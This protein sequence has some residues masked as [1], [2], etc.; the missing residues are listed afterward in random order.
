MCIKNIQLKF[1]FAHN[2]KPFK[3]L[4]V[5]VNADNTLTNIAYS[6]NTT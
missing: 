1:Y 4:K 3:Q 6:Q 5:L 2:S